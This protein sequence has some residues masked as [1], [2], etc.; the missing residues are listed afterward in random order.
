[1]RIRNPPKQKNKTEK[2]L[3]KEVQRSKAIP[4]PSIYMLV[5]RTPLKCHVFESLVPLSLLFLFFFPLPNIL[6]YLM[7][8]L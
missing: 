5:N 3:E 8:N 7:N 4:N 1:M 6:F 2:Y